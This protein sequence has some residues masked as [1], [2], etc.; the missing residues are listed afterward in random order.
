MTQGP[1]AGGD[2]NAL[3]AKSLGAVPLRPAWAALSGR[4][5]VNFR[6][7]RT[8]FTVTKRVTGSRCAEAAKPLRN[9]R[10]TLR[11]PV[12][13]VHAPGRLFPL[14]DMG[15]NRPGNHLRRH[16]VSEERFQV[17]TNGQLAPINALVVDPI[18]GN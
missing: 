8:A 1:P 14:F 10:Q 11:P 12:H 13:T 4:Q 6:G 16:S 2:A 18:A 5:W 7:R 17:D 3:P 9:L 15:A